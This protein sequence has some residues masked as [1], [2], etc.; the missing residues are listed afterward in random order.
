M[1]FLEDLR[2]AVNNGNLQQIAHLLDCG[3]DVN[4]TD[5]LGRTPLYFAS[6]KGDPA[7]VLLL[8]IECGCQLD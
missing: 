3:V 8:L 1:P 7:F 5:T 6:H 2:I 4:G